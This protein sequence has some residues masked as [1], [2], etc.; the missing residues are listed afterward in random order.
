[1]KKQSGLDEHLAPRPKSRGVVPLKDMLVEEMAFVRAARKLAPNEPLVGL[2]L[3]GG[4]VR[5]GTISLGFLERLTERDLL[6]CFDYISSVSGGSYASG[7]LFASKQAFGESSY[8]ALFGE[9]AKHELLRTG[10]YLAL[11]SGVRRYFQMVR[12]FA[13]Y[14]SSLVLSLAWLPALFVVAAGLMAALSE[15]VSV[16][17]STTW[18]LTIA[19]LTALLPAVVRL[20][21]L[22]I[23]DTAGRLA[24]WAG[25]GAYLTATVAS[26]RSLT[27]L[28]QKIAN[29]LEG[30]ALLVIAGCLAIAGVAK[31]ADWGIR[32]LQGLSGQPV[33]FENRAFL[34]VA[35]SV[36]LAFIIAVFAAADSWSLY[37]FFRNLIDSSFCGA[38]F[39]AAGRSQKESTLLQRLRSRWAAHFRDRVLLR[40]LGGLMTEPGS[41]R[42][43]YPLFNAAT[44]FRESKKAP[45]VRGKHINP[46][47]WNAT[48]S[49]QAA[50]AYFLFSPRFCGTQETGYKR[51]N[52][53]DQIYDNLMLAD[54]ITCSAASL[55]PLLYGNASLPVTV[56]LMF[57]NLN[58]ACFLPNPD[59][60][61]RKFWS[62]FWPSRY[63]AMLRGGAPTNASSL[64]V[65]DGAFADNLGVIELLRRRCSLITCVDSTFDPHYDFHDLRR[66]IARARV[67]LGI[68]IRLPADAEER[69]RPSAITGFCATPLVVLDVEGTM[70][71]GTVYTAK[72]N[73][74]KAALD[75]ALRQDEGRWHGCYDAYHPQFPQET[76]GNQFFDPEQWHAYN[77]LG[78][79]LADR[80]LDTFDFEYERMVSFEVGREFLV[81]SNRARATNGPQSTQTPS[82]SGS[83]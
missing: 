49:A 19:L 54:A 58:L 72:I 70:P 77:T 57:G 43:P 27:L 22:P 63:I 40:D 53:R 5:S 64:L 24:R 26:A 6:Q 73:Y 45:G 36:A 37:A 33:D 52:D 39:R 67:E 65:A 15:Y 7:Y 31:A 29:Y 79:V 47:I 75:E 1:M 78:K 42:L 23:I 12:L 69:M 50:P 2:A 32:A 8:E 13:A 10:R 61:A 9:R 30:V 62:R 48:A 56:A 18:A 11:G 66:L 21:L 68:E 51:L 25:R 60:R 71:D 80:F 35:G 46:M 4:G 41:R 59:S 74:I 81:P 20:V 76:T 55:T 16:E 44:Y 38:A 14:A 83:R 17:R 3:S 82:S 28:S 34:T